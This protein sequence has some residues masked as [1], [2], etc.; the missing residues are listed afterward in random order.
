MS[1]DER[2][3]ASP[4]AGGG[5]DGPAPPG[6]APK[7]G[8]DGPGPGP[9]PERDQ[10]GQSG[11]EGGGAQ[12]QQ[13]AAPEPRP[14]P[15]SILKNRNRGGSRERR[16]YQREA[17][18]S[19]NRADVRA[20]TAVGGDQINYHFGTPAAGGGAR[21][22]AQPDAVIEE[23][24]H[25]FVEP[26]D[27][28]AVRQAMEDGPLVIVQGSKGEGRYAVARWLLRD[29]A[30]VYSLNADVALTGLTGA[31]LSQD[32]GYIKRNLTRAE[33]RELDAPAVTHLTGLL[34]ERG[35]RMVV[36]VGPAVA[37]ADDA[38]AELV[39]RPGRVRNRALIVE[40]HLA[41]RLST[42]TADAILDDEEVAALLD[43]ELA[44]E[45]PPSHA[46]TV[47]VELIRAREGDLPLARTVRGALKQSGDER[48]RSWFK[49]LSSLS[50]Q[51]MGLAISVLGGESYETV[52]HAAEMLRRELMPPRQ[53]VQTTEDLSDAPLVDT[54]EEWLEA[55]GAR[56]Y[57]DR[58]PTRHGAEA[59]AEL[60]RFNG[61]K[62]QENVLLYFFRAFDRSRGPLLHWLRDCAAHDAEGVRYRTAVATGLLTAQSYDLVRASVV[63]P[64]AAAEDHR[65][66]DAAAE[67]LAVTAKE[68]GML[69]AVRKTLEG[70]AE[71]ES[72]WLR[73]TAARCWQVLY[74]AEGTGA[75]LEMLDSAGEDESLIVT[76]AVCSSLTDLWEER[77]DDPEV[78]DRLIEW[79]TGGDERRRLTG[80]LAFLVAAVELVEELPGDHGTAVWPGLLW[81]AAG[82]PA[83]ERRIARLWQFA[84]SDRSVIDTAKAVLFDWVKTAEPEP[85]VR[86]ALT[87]LLVATAA[88][89]RHT[90]TRIRHESVKW[91]EDAPDL[92]REVRA[93]LGGKA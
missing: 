9:G 61:T 22:K 86:H 2:P 81:S 42:G 73:A 35:C 83:L 87:R 68:D 17:L 80:R 59:P 69:D 23:I 55:L 92:A 66:R 7:D 63:L 70:W 84:L 74:G 89:D 47:A 18:S 29:S 8:Q 28:A 91:A 44:G 24:A 41:W 65:L 40:R 16:A 54:R 58:A 6:A 76:D 93:A 56:T 12:G 26:E 11:E 10:P 49:E 33:A 48:V 51:C 85:A 52:A 37:F 13:E 82:D 20:D 43:G 62:A 34:R 30:R 5:G 14:D 4:P 27:F 90:G 78:P 19:F 50:V 36:T 77:R 57:P 31:D 25:T 53:N 1:G 46:R 32:G 71:E 21:I 79:A 67:A 3:P 15:G 45:G 75:V 72:E 38:V 64:W 88:A 60:V 39:V